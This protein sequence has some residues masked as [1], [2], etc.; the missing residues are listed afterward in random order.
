[1]WL[2]CIWRCFPFQE[3]NSAAKSDCTAASNLILRLQMSSKCLIKEI[4]FFHLPCSS[5]SRGSKVDLTAEEKQQ[6]GFRSSMHVDERQSFH[7]FWKWH[8]PWRF[9]KVLKIIQ[10]SSGLFFLENGSAT[11][12]LSLTAL[13][14]CHF[15]HFW[16]V[17]AAV[18]DIDIGPVPAESRQW[19]SPSFACQVRSWCSSGPIISPKWFYSC[20]EV[21]EQNLA[22][23][24]KNAAFP[25]CFRWDQCLPQCLL[26]GPVPLFDPCSLRHAAAKKN[27]CL[28]DLT[29]KQHSKQHD[30]MLY[31]G[32]CYVNYAPP[33]NPPAP[34]HS[35][36]SLTQPGFG[37][38]AAS[39]LSLNYLCK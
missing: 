14:R 28:S 20:Q 6:D 31:N 29:P 39:G 38:N 5:F 26:L 24:R 16:C 32:S 13:Q 21:F 19:T 10:K 35:C 18:I 8:N 12:H 27:T 25:I 4:V 1:M 7:K 9:I 37:V 11:S 3:A 34:Q 33:F 22:G 36:H 23:W 17:K 30:L 15:W 2:L